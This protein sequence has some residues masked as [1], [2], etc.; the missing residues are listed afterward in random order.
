[1][2]IKIDF[3]RGTDPYIYRDALYY[4]QEQFDAITQEE[5][6]AEK[7]RRYNNWYTLVTTPPPPVEEVVD[8]NAVK[9]I[10][11]IAGETYYLLTSVP[12]SGAKLIEVNGHWYQKV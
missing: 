5:I 11:T 9:D 1:M 4:T 2:D 7:D 12:S 6:E 10:L 8:E 3:E